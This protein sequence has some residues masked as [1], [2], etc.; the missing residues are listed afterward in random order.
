MFVLS[1]L[2]LPFSSTVIGSFSGTRAAGLPRA[3]GPPG[4]LELV[5]RQGGRR[6]SAVRQV[7]CL[8]RRAAEGRVD[9]QVEQAVVAAVEQHA[10][11]VEPLL[12][13][14]SVLGGL[15][16]GL[17]QVLGRN[18]VALVLVDEGEAAG[19]Q[20]P[21]AV[22]GDAWL[23]DGEVR[24]LD[25]GVRRGKKAGALQA[26]T[27]VNDKNWPLMSSPATP[28]ACC[29][30]ASGAPDAAGTSP[31]AGGSVGVPVPVDDVAEAE[32]VA[33][34]EA[35]AEVDGD[36]R[37]WRGGLPAWAAVEPDPAM[38]VRVASYPASDPELAGGSGAEPV[39]SRPAR[40][41]D[42]VTNAACVADVA[43]EAVFCPAVVWVL[44]VGVAVAVEVPA[45]VVA[46]AV[47]DV[48]VAGVTG[49]ATA[50]PRVR[51][52]ASPR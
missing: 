28:L 19:R 47:P 51:W 10:R 44:A 50:W 3:V 12:V 20:A 32:A 29:R 30:I 31:I 37:R 41:A 5:E 34:A 2:K 27:W 7:G 15:A 52:P 8:P 21:L 4:R 46:V 38:R 11:A 14:R 45:G 48:L 25:R 6:R 1:V 16:V 18:V 24:R 43:G 42:P 36:G 9:E 35:E 17:G 40:C 13:G 26:P 22:P 33:V 39:T 23:R 49:P